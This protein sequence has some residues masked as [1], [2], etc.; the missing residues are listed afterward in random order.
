M[1]RNLPHFFKI[2]L[3]LARE[4]GHP[5]GD[6]D[7]GYE[8]VAPLDPDGH[9]RSDLWANHVTDCVVRA[10]S[11]GQPD[12]KGVLARNEEGAWYFDY[13]AAQANDDEYG[14][15]FGE[16]RFISGEY[17]SIADDGGKMHTFRVTQVEK[18]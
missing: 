5:G 1:D 8:F 12:R 2:R 7:T 10:F 15:R 16:E 18:P 9:I 4:A 6:S 11:H 17:V 14:Y 13:D 3:E